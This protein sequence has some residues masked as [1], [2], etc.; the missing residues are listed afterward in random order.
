[1]IIKNI[2]FSQVLGHSW[3]SLSVSTIKAGDTCVFR[4]GDYEWGFKFPSLKVSA[5]TNGERK[6]GKM[7]MEIRYCFDVP[8]VFQRGS[9]YP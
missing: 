5:E 7:M 6:S 2:V 4:L 9:K 1:M 3:D 8:R